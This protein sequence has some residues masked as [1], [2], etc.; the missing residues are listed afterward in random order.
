MH[1]EKLRIHNLRCLAD[2]AIELDPGINVFLG[3]NGAGKTSLL[4]A[5]FL[6]SHARSFRSG[7]KEALLRLGTPKLSIFA[8]LRRKDDSLI[9]MGLGR[10]ASRW[11][12]KRD[13][14]AISLGKLVQDCAVVC[15]D[16][17]SHALISGA[18]EERRRFLDWGVFHVEHEFLPMWQR[19]Q[20]ALKQRNS[21]LRSA[22]P[23][24]NAVFEPWEIELSDTARQIDQQ[25]ESYLNLLSAALTGYTTRLLP[26]LGVFE[27]RYRRGWAEGR[28]LLDQLRDSRV[29]DASRG[30]TS[31]GAHR[32]DWSLGF[33]AAPQREHFS[34][35]QE[36]L[37]ATACLLA[38]AM[39]YA[40]TT[41]EWPVVC[42]DDL[43]SELDQ[44]HQTAV[45]NELLSAGAQILVTGTEIPL[46]LND[47][48][49]RT[50]HVEQGQLAALL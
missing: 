40:Q 30:H 38:Q 26:E 46:A 18:A 50:F 29:R 49:R 9:R 45:V 35:G 24:N 39:L 27:L 10:E 13:G 22:M 33:E 36:K 37:V 20:R 11:Q 19:Y 2:V 34:R 1:F 32:A 12:A 3:G 16:P 6:L 44:P 15:F 47:H 42:L 8:E 25:R 21:L 7:A 48:T 31:L 17:G 28:D 14:T 43:A 23:T 4:E 41:G 5:V